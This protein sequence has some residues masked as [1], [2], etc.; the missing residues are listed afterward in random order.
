MKNYWDSKGDRFF[1]STN[2]VGQRRLRAQLSSIKN[3]VAVGSGKGGVGKSTLSMQLALSLMSAG[4]QVSI[5]DADF[6]NPTI[7]RLANVRE[8]AIGSLG[9]IVPQTEDGIGIVSLP[10]HKATAP[11][12]REFFPAD[13]VAGER[14]ECLSELSDVLCSVAWGELDYLIIDLPP[15]PDKLLQAAE[16]LGSKVQFVL[17]SIPTELS[18]DVLERTVQELESHGSS[19]LG[20][21][22]NMKGYLCPD[23]AEIRPL[24]PEKSETT[25]LRRLGE[26]PFEPMLARLAD[27]GLCA[28]SWSLL[29]VTSYVKVVTDAM[30]ELLEPR[31]ASRLVTM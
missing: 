21:I 17:V 2:V 8:T 27:H 6:Y 16:A 18:Y 23:S 15:G 29:D 30:L 19:V 9:A 12:A 24:F 26:V 22:E 7:S 25:H 5:L 3:V 10:A 13:E 11:L 1:G 14:S 20:Y 4:K 28:E 31:A